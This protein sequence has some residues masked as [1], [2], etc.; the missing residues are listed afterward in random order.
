MIVSGTSKTA[1]LPMSDP[2]A[3]V[4]PA[5]TDEWGGQTLRRR[6]PE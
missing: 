3:G 5:G 4:V 6:R 2:A 1:I